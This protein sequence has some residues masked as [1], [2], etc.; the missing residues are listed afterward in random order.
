MEL[1]LVLPEEAFGD[2]VDVFDEYVAILV[3]IWVF[4]GLYAVDT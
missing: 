3:S 2:G 4:V 1:L